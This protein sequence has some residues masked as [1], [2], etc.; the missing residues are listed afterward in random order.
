MKKILMGLILSLSV[1]VNADRKS[2][3]DS[4]FCELTNYTYTMKGLK[5]I[6]DKVEI[7]KL[8]S[9]ISPLGEAYPTCKKSLQDLVVD[10]I[11][12]YQRNY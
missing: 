5:I 3:F 8:G 4:C 6:A 9:G 12:P 10:N 7:F 2:H 11:C 1:S